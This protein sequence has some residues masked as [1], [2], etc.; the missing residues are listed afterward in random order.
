MANKKL[1]FGLSVTSGTISSE[2]LDLAF[3]GTNRRGQ[4]LNAYRVKSI[5]I[6]IDDLDT[7]ADNDLLLKFQLATKDLAGDSFLTIDDKDELLTLALRDSIPTVGTN[8]GSGEEKS[9]PNMADI[10]RDQGVLFLD[11]RDFSDVYI[12]ENKFWLNGDSSGQDAAEV[13]HSFING[14]YVHLEEDDIAA[15]TQG[16]TLS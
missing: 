9:Q 3:K 1:K 7:V 14:R 11:G 12:V 6:Q 10:I 16:V 15:L 13:W 4:P 2:Q 8:A 5:K